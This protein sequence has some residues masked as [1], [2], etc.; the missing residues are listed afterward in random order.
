[1]R[2]LC[3]PRPCEN[4][5]DQDVVRTVLAVNILGDA[6]YRYGSDRKKGIQAL[7]AAMSGAIPRICIARFMLYANTCKLI[8]VLTRGIVLVRK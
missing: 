1:M 6:D 2:D 8:S 3:R 7:I 5:Q 4:T